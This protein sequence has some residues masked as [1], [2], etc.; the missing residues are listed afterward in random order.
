MSRTPS[1]R[2][3]H[4][5]DR[6]FKCLEVYYEFRWYYSRARS[7]RTV[8]ATEQH[9][10]SARYRAISSFP[11]S[12]MWPLCWYVACHYDGY[13]CTLYVFIALSIFR[14]ISLYLSLCV[15]CSL[16]LSMSLNL[17]ISLLIFLSHTQSLCHEGSILLIFYLFFEKNFQKIVCLFQ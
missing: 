12:L 10:S 8:L 17:F 3:H 1:R 11:N 13:A 9:T 16:Y 7:V 15:Y 6:V 4:C 5:T 14:Y 2:P